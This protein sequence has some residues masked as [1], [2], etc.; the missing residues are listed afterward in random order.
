[1]G[2]FGS[3][4]LRLA[5]A[6]LASASI[7]GCGGGKKNTPLF[8]GKITLT[9]SGN[10]SLVLGGVII[11]SSSA[12]TSTGTNLAVPITFSS[13]DTS[14]LNVGPTG[15]ACAGHWDVTF[16]IC[17]PGGTG[18]AQVTASTLGATSIPTYVFVH[19]PIDNVSVT[20][21]LHNNI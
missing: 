4:K 10:T 20:G 16:T 15:V 8:P 14:V 3:A 9:P 6:I 17:T 18:V 13:S 21:I 2:R 5:V 12:Q 7:A 1:M 11:F 19:A